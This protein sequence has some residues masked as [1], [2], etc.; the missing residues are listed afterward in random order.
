MVINVLGREHTFSQ[1]QDNSN[2]EEVAEDSLDIPS[3][4]SVLLSPMST[5]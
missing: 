5:I 3:T 2:N 1:R 4:P